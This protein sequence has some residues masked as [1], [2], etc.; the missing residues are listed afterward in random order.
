LL[1]YIV[2]TNIYTSFWNFAFKILCAKRSG[3]INKLFFSK[4]AKWTEWEHHYGLFASEVNLAGWRNWSQEKQFT[5]MAKLFVNKEKPAI[6]KFISCLNSLICL[7]KWIICLI[8]FISLPIVEP[9][10][11]WHFGFN[12]TFI[13]KV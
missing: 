3:A 10:F 8:L 2:T 11:G 12:T 4:L 9:I 13:F 5:A 1:L 6:C 7:H